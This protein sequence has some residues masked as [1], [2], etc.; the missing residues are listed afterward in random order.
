ML[1]KFLLGRN[2]AG[3]RGGVCLVSVFAGDLSVA[4]HYQVSASYLDLSHQ[5]L[6]NS[7]NEW[8]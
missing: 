8:V 4:L 3:I 1:S 7:R 6:E 2:E 5:N